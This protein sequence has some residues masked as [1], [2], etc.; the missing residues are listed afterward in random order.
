MRN[1]FNTKRYDSV[2]VPAAPTKNAYPCGTEMITDMKFGQWIPAGAYFAIP[3]DKIKVGQNAFIRTIPMVTVP[4]TGFHVKFITFFTSL[5]NLDDDADKI[6]TGFDEDENPFSGS[7]ESWKVSKDADLAKWSNYDYFGFQ[8]MT[9]AIY[10]NVPDRCKPAD[11]WRKNLYFIYNEWL[12][13][14]KLQDAIDEDSNNDPIPANYA[15]DRYTAASLKPQ[16]GDEATIPLEASNS[17]SFGTVDDLNLRDLVLSNAE[18]IEFLRNIP[19]VGDV[20]DYAKKGS[21]KYN[22]F[23]DPSETYTYG[24]DPTE[25][26]R[27]PIG[28]IRSEIGT[29]IDSTINPTSAANVPGSN[30]IPLGVDFNS[31]WKQDFIDFLNDNSV[32][33]NGGMG[34]NDTRLA[35]ARQLLAERMNRVGSRYNEYLRSNYGLAPADETLQ[36]PVFLGS[37]VCPVLINE[38]TQTS[39]SNSSPLGDIAGKGI[40]L[41][42]SYTKS[43]LCKEFGVIQTLMCIVPDVYYSQGIPKQFTYKSKYD[44]FNP[45]FQ[46]LGEQEVLNSEIFVNGTT[47]GDD[48]DEDGDDGVWGYNM[49]YEELKVPER[50]ISGSF[51]DQLED[52]TLARKFS[53]RPHLNGDFV[54][55]DD[56]RDNLNRI[57]VA[58]DSSKFKQFHVHIYNDI[59]ALRPLVRYPIPATLKGM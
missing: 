5:R 47:H 4:F 56:M 19:N 27:Y 13:E 2:P 59:R 31:D 15:R 33:I 11:Y 3:G 49:L 28:Y 54:K 17:V 51:R 58:F 53:Q 38:V 32:S 21:L 7:F 24:S 26:S 14:P 42:S 29:L 20:T 18:D 9:K 22:M 37:S 52:Y 44:F 36:R 55:C 23:T 30:Y 12:R 1:R 6:I 57:F 41:N 10:D 8:T 50:R 40:A 39:E 45:I 46:A 34:I 43:Y 16:L 25:P 35:F 48:P